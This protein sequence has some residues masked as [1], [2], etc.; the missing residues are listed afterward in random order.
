MRELLKF[1]FFYIV[2]NKYFGFLILT[3][4]IFFVLNLSSFFNP[5]KVLYIPVSHIVIDSFKGYFEFFII[6]IITFFSGELYW[7]EKEEHVDAFYYITP[8]GSLKMYLAKHIALFLSVGLL[9][10]SLII[11]GILFQFT[12]QFFDINL[13]LYFLQ[14]AVLD[15]HYYALI[16]V[17]SF[18]VQSIVNH[19]YL[20]FVLVIAFIAFSYIILP[21]L[22]ITHHLLLY[23]KS[24]VL[25]FSDING[26]GEYL[27]PIF[28]FRV[29]WTFAALLLGYM[30][31][32]FWV[33]YY[34]TD[35]KNRT[36]IARLRFI[37]SKAYP[38]SF[39][40]GFVFTGIVIFYNTNILNAYDTR[41]NKRMARA[42][43]EKK[44]K[45]Y[46]STVQPKVF[47]ALLDVKFRPNEKSIDVNGKYYLKSQD[48]IIKEVL[49]VL[50]SQNIVF[51][52]SLDL[53][54]KPILDYVELS[55]PYTF[56]Y[57]DK[58][59]NS[60]IFKLKE[61]LEKKDTLT[62]DFSFSIHLKGFKNSKSHYLGFIDNGYAFYAMFWPYFGY[63]KDIELTNNKVRSKFGLPKLE[64]EPKSN[65]KYKSKGEP[66]EVC[67]T[68]SMPKNYDALVS[69]NLIK[70]T[71][72]HG[73]LKKEF[74]SKGLPDFIVGQYDLTYDTW[75][76]K[77]IEVYHHS[78]HKYNV[79]HVIKTIKSTLDYC[80]DNFEDYPFDDLKIV[81]FPYTPF[82]YASKSL[83]F[84]PEKSFLEDVEN[85]KRDR[86]GQV[87][88]HEVAHQWW[89]LKL[90]T[91][92]TKGKSF[93]SETM[94][95]YVS[96]MVLKQ[97]RNQGHLNYLRKMEKHNYLTNRS[98]ED[99]QEVPL[100]FVENQNYIHYNKGTSIMYALQYYIG[101]ETLNEGMRAFY[102]KSISK[103]NAQAKSIDLYHEIK[104]VTPDS[105]H[106]FLEDGL[107]KITFYDFTLNTAKWSEIN[108]TLT[109]NLSAKKT[110]LN[111]LGK[112]NE[113]QML[114]E[115]VEIGFFGSDNLTSPTQFFK[116][117]SGDNNIQVKLDKKP[118]RVVLDPNE[119]LMEKQ[120]ND[121]SLQTK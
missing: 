68:I 69:G 18:A 26:Y 60:V 35:L 120:V 76:G 52:T 10:F 40:M 72:N 85:A 3:S 80:S 86:I 93:L 94:A 45:K 11:S 108:H 31:Y 90:E 84:Y 54:D 30:G 57:F 74:T 47:K 66:P 121:N 70:D 32:L 21:W 117:N 91:A 118:L 43:F 25:F 102:K 29:Y 15:M 28:F 56:K 42:S 7:K 16:I 98:N 61:A 17:L 79:N 51:N 24:P 109:L 33:S 75:K 5:Y 97:Q 113:A 37:N 101:E 73:F 99:K 83:I 64:F 112:E 49:F 19:K 71:M 110:Y 82:A 78:K 114:K 104:Q 53:D 48:T 65:S 8:I 38:I 59:Y 100:L 92:K 107:K 116:I 95:Q 22:G 44:Y 103:L 36:K 81:E 119:L 13:E 41:Y 20:G 2:R 63:D 14:I 9:L 106:Y 89:S 4:I 34:D 1:Y 23:G 87:I 27:K 55:K 12:Q 39:F 111:T 115:Y 46:E 77:R 58:T 50:P 6:L 96:L 62:L 67:L 88:A 105:L